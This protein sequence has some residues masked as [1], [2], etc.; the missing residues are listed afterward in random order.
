LGFTQLV[1]REIDSN[2]LFHILGKTVNLQNEDFTI[3]GKLI[4]FEKVGQAK[5]KPFVLILL[6]PNGQ[7][8]IAKWEGIIYW[9]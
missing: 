7:M 3:S 1:K 2:L 8:A 4:R 5:H 6:L 9:R